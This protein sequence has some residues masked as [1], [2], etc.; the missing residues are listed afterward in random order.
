MPFTRAADW[1]VI[2]TANADAHWLDQLAIGGRLL[3][4]LGP[5]G[6]DQ[7]L[8]ID[9]V[10]DKEF[11]E[12]SHGG[13]RFG[14]IVDLSDQ[15]P[16]FNAAAALEAAAPIHGRHNEAVRKVREDRLAASTSHV[17]SEALAAMGFERSAIDA[18]LRHAPQSLEDAI[19]LLLHPPSAA[20]SSSAR[21]HEAEKR[22]MAEQQRQL[23][24]QQ[25]RCSVPLAPKKPI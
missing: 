23:E 11:K 25:V 12:V 7:Q 20:R 17:D 8:S 16:G 2:G 4:P 18:A 19:T 14:S 1:S 13:V 5:E 21:T 15:L 10:A 3:V 24:C 6:G 22:R 9:R